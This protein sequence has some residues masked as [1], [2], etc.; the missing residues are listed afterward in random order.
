VIARL[1]HTCR[2]MPNQIEGEL[3]DGRPFY[4][5]GRWGYWYLAVGSVGE[6]IWDICTNDDVNG[7]HPNA[8]WWEEAEA[9]QFCRDRLAEYLA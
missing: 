1:E 8:G 2:M 3:D 6:T 9:E 7:D 5:R 4:F